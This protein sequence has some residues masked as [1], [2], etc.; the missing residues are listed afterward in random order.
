MPTKEHLKIADEVWIATAQLH[1]EHPEAEDFSIE[2]IV[3][4]AGKFE[5]PFVTN[6][7]RLHEKQVDGIQFITPLDRVPI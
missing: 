7:G 5:D 2:E 3:W 1:Q 4:R 6:D